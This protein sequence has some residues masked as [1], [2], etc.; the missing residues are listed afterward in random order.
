MAVRKLT[1]MRN[2]AILKAQRDIKD[3]MKVLEKELE[4]E[5]S[6]R[7]MED[8]TLIKV[9][10]SYVIKNKYGLALKPTANVASTLEEISELTKQFRIDV[11]IKL[12]IPERIEGKRKKD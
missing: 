9:E 3:A 11:V 1:K 10:N 5:I 2:D 8:C 4:K 12:G 7:I 6:N